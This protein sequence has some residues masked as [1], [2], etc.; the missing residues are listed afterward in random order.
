L[1]SGVEAEVA[2]RGYLRPAPTGICEVA[3]VT[4]VKGAP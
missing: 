4:A 1:L 2:K 3:A